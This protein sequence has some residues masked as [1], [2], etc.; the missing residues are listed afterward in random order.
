[1]AR[2]T[3]GERVQRIMDKRLN[4]LNGTWEYTPPD[5]TAVEEA[6]LEQLPRLLM[7][8]RLTE[9]HVSGSELT[10]VT[11]GLD[12]LDQMQE[13]KTYLGKMRFRI[14]FPIDKAMVGQLTFQMN[15][16]VENLDNEKRPDAR[17]PDH[18]MH[19]PHVACVGPMAYGKVAACWNEYSRPMETHY[20]SLDAVAM[21][22]SLIRYVTTFTSGYEAV[23][24]PWFHYQQSERY[25][26]HPA[27]RRKLVRNRVLGF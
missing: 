13:R 24:H 14:Q 10:V 3:P 11:K 22:H 21:V 18:V 15:V 4:S 26:E 8:K 23:S 1:M 6:L 17:H 25:E 19:S 2:L 7:D 5:P 16:Q 20:R 12:L 27:P 9:V